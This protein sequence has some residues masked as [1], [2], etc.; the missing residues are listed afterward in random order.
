VIRNDQKVIELK[1]QMGETWKLAQSSKHLKAFNGYNNV[2]T[3]VRHCQA[4][5]APFFNHLCRPKTMGIR[6]RASAY[7]YLNSN[8]QRENQNKNQYFLE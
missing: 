7:Y 1:E 3:R 6:R 5:F 2:I 8:R 4:F